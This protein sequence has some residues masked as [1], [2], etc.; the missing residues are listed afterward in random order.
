MASWLPV[1]FHLQPPTGVNRVRYDRFSPYHT[2]SSEFGLT[3][4]PSRAYA[5]IYALPEESLM[6]LAYSFEDSGRPR[7]HVHRAV[8]PQPGQRALQEAVQRWNDLWHGSQ[9]ILRVNDDGQCLQITDTRPCTRRTTW[10]VEGI[11]AEIYRRCDSAQTPA[12]LLKQ[13]SA[14][15]RA[16]VSV[17]EAA[18]AIDTLCEAKIL[19][20]LNGK[21]L[22]LG[23]NQ[24]PGRW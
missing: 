12:M 24:N 14:W 6:R 8:Q 19:S 17:E 18:A 4:E 13:L 2:R 7:A 9:P 11:A 21:L 16:D 10:S 23:V 3:L 5:Y 1:I 22:A 20:R 15:R